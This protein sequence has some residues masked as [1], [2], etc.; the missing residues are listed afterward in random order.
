MRKRVWILGFIC[1]VNLNIYGQ[2]GIGKPQLKRDSIFSKLDNNKQIFYF[3]KSKA[4]KPMPLV[5]QLHSWSFNA[6]SLKTLGLDSLSIS[7]NYN[8]VFPDFRGINN[9]AKACGSDFV[10]SDLDEVIDWALVNLPVDKSKIYLVGY[11]GGGFATMVMYMK[12]KHKIKAFSSWV[13]ISDLWAWYGESVQRKNRYA[14]EL[15]KCVD[16]SIP[17]SVKLANRSPLF[18]K[19]PKKLRKKS[20]FHLYAGIHDGHGRTMPVPISQ[21]INMYNKLLK[22]KGEKDTKNYISS[23]EMANMV[24]TQQFPEDLSFTQIAGKKAFK[25]SS[26]KISIC[27]FEGGHD[28]LSSEVLKEIE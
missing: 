24:Q 13:G 23:I 10:V 26:G 1:T 18:M 12:S 16:S 22:D 27:I 5:V 15:L 9:H 14:A 21:T 4:T 6:D 28:M 17:D 19:A 11:S 25:R 8:Y 20:S 7:K 3:A 2:F